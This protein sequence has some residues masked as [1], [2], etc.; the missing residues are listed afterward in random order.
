MSR[1]NSRSWKF[2]T[3]YIP[4]AVIGLVL[5]TICVW[6]LPRRVNDV[7][8]VDGQ[9]RWRSAAAPPQ[10]RIVWQPA[11]RLP[12]QIAASDKRENFVRPQLADGGATLYYTV[13]RTDGSTDIYRSQFDGSIWTPGQ[14]VDE[15]NSQADDFGPVISA[16]G[17]QLYLYS[18]RAG[19]Q[20]GFDL[21]LSH[22]TA[23][24]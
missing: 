8:S 14:A 10:R 15:L 17:R 20:G 24:G 5:L 23:D 21:Y 6:L 4:V 18:D 2:K 3:W 16:D 22:R 1:R 13:Q 19:G 9:H 11:K 7:V 12:T